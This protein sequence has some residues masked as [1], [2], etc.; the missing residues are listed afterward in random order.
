MSSANVYYLKFWNYIKN[1]FFSCKFEFQ[2][3]LI[4]FLMSLFASKWYKWNVQIRNTNIY[5]LQPLIEGI[6]SVLQP[7]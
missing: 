7:T 2:K 6:V 4:G 3:K 5:N 1:F